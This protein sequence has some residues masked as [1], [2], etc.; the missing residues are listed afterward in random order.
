MET[1]NRTFKNLLLSL[2]GKEIFYIYVDKNIAYSEFTIKEVF[3]DYIVIV[4][5]QYYHNIPITQIKGIKIKKEE[6]PKKARG[7][8]GFGCKLMP[9]K[10]KPKKV[11]LSL[12]ERVN[13]HHNIS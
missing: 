7:L 2:I 3:E 4:G 8:F 9:R 1:K 11:K 13:T 6:V 12:E 5:M 10:Q